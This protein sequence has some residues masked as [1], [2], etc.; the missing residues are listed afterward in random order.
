MMRKY[1]NGHLAECKAIFPGV[2]PKTVQNLWETAFQQATTA[3]LDSIV[4]NTTIDLVT[5]FA[6]PCSAEALKEMTSLM[7][8]S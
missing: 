6:M 7:N 3:F 2:S 4:S 8:M 5:D 1:G